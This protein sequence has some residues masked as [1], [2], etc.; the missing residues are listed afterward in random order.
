MKAVNKGFT[1]IELMIVVAIVAIL[2]AIA[3]P[4]YQS[5]TEKAKMTELMQASSPIKAAIEIYA[6]EKGNFTGVTAGQDG[7]PTQKAIGE[8][9]NIAD[10]TNSYTVTSTT[11]N[12]VDLSIKG[13]VDLDKHYFKLQGKRT[14]NG[15]VSWYKKCDV[16]KGSDKTPLCVKDK[17]YTDAAG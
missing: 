8:G 2:A 12:Q 7:L 3:L 17:D 9:P 15:T 11:P 10:E 4:A 6:F 13:A 1:L 5:Y 16:E 14:D